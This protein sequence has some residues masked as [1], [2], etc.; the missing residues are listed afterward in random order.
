MTVEIIYYYFVHRRV[1]YCYIDKCITIY[2][3]VVYYYCRK[4]S[5]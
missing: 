2:L 5:P 4:C 3:D 1:M